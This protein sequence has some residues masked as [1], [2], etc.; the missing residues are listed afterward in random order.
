RGNFLFVPHG[1][2]VM[3]NLKSQISNILDILSEKIKKI[4]KDRKSSFI[5]IAPIFERKEENI[6]HF[7]KLKFKDA[8]IHI[9]PEVTWELDITPNEDELLSNMRKTTRYL[10]KQGIKNKDIEIVQ[11]NKAEDLKIFNQV[12]KETA[13]RNHF[14]PFP[15]E[16]LENEFLTFDTDKEISIFFGKLKGKVVSVALIVFWQNMAFYHHSGSLSEYR[17]IPV[18]YLLQWRVIQEA[19]RRGCKIYNFWGIAPEIT[20]KSQISKSKHP[21]AGL[22]LFK[23]GFGGKRE[24]YVKTQDL[25]LS[26]KY[27]L[28]Y[29]FEKARKLKRRL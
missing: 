16:Y 8:P 24:E 6:N 15:S 21:W 27:W 18:S 22:S 5:R 17:K 1:P 29:I 9:H 20:D 3:L 7:K 13:I 14:I 28:T 11:S 19:K 12:Y 25:P 26:F 23:M 2:V 4:A 10:I